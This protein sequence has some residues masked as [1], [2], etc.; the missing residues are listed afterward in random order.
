MSPWRNLNFSGKL[1]AAACIINVI[2]A[3]IQAKHG[4]Y[5]A[6][7]SIFIAAWCGMWTYHDKY[8]HMD[9]KDINEEREE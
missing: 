1:L 9:S 5:F 2:V 4:S 8:Q 3:I 7:F 6:V